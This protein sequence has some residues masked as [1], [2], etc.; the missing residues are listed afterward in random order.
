IKLLR[1]GPDFLHR[2]GDIPVKVFYNWISG[3]LTQKYSLPPVSTKAI[4]VICAVYYF[5]MQDADLTGPGQ[6]GDRLIQMA[7]ANT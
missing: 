4:W 5:A 7:S 1:E 2:L 6:E 3:I